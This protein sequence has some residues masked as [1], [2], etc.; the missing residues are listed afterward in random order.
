M[1]TTGDATAN[2]ALLALYGALDQAVTSNHGGATQEIVERYLPGSTGI[3]AGWYDE[4]LGFLNHPPHPAPRDT[5]ESPAAPDLDDALTVLQARRLPPL[6]PGTTS[7]TLS[8]VQWARMAYA[9]G[10]LSQLPG[11]ESHSEQFSQALAVVSPTLE[12]LESSGQ[13]AAVSGGGPPDNDDLL[14]LLQRSF[15]SRHDW[16]HVMKSAVAKK[17]IDPTVAAVPL[18][19]ARV[20]WVRGQLCAVLTTEF[21]SS[22]VSLEQ[23][24]SIIDPLNWA[25][26]MSFFC[27]MDPEPPRSDGWSRVL[28]HV[29]TTCSLNGT[30]QMVTPLKY[31]KGP[32]ASESLITA[33]VD[34]A[35]DDLPASGEKGD[36]RVVVDEGFISM[37][38]SD[39]T[40]A[41]L[42]V[43]VRTKKVVGFR[44][45]PW[46]AGAI[47]ACS[48]GYGYEG[49]SMLIDGVAQH[50][51][52]ANGWTGW[53]PSTT[54]SGSP[55]QPGEPGSPGEP[56]DVSGRAVVLAVDMLNECVN[57]MSAKSAAIA[58]KWATGA[59]PIEETIAYTSDL[60]IRLATDPWRYLQRLGDPTQ[61]DN[62]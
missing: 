45:L 22:K 41:S 23:L 48:M 38:S 56:P 44:D 25:K 59:I 33:F 31:W 27:E 49:M 12:T 51:K 29:S 55:K 37:T 50:A 57:D 7:N 24:K 15:L 32:P 4:L 30:P 34:Y 36:G 62:K 5:E 1:A 19:E 28:E 11:Y 3:H 43:R 53:T 39:A 6:T 14:L 58:A 13:A 61:G 21:E 2:Q 10:A 17:L 46:I 52:N 9:I 47:F 16:P 60:A 26:C 8:T 42:G 54:P 18:C 40:P 35:L 20:K